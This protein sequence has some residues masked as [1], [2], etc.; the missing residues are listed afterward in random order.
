V[1]A[2]AA[3]TILTFLEFHPGAIVFVKGN[4]SAKTRLYRIGANYCFHEFGH[5]F[6]IK[7]LY[8]NAWESFVPGK[9][10][11]AFSISVKRK[12]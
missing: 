7:G 6:D 1:L 2:T 12:I 4:T 11:D 5:L 9:N 8:H 10:Y 3:T